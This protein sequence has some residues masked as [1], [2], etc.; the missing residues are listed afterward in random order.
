MRM[1]AVALRESTLAFACVWVS[2]I[3]LL[4]GDHGSFVN[5]PYGFVRNLLK[6]GRGENFRKSFPHILYK[7]PN[8]C[9]NRNND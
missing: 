4:V 7:L 2:T 5:D 6:G 9:Y 8:S 1:S 3:S